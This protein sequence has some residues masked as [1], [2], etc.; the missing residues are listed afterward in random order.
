MCS[1]MPVYSIGTIKKA[2]SKPI[3]ASLALD[4]YNIGLVIRR[5]ITRRLLSARPLLY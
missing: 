4:Y 5:E 2:V 3:L 1:I